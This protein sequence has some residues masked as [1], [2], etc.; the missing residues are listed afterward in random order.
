MS[1]GV[2]LSADVAPYEKMKLRLLNAGHSVLAYAA[3][4]RGHTQVHDAMQDASL[5][6]PKSGL[7]VPAGHG[8]KVCR[9]LAAPSTP[10]KPP[11]GHGS[12]VV[13]LIASLRLPAGQGMQPSAAKP[14]TSLKVPG[15]QA[16]Q[17]NS[18]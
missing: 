15:M 4:L 10:Q 2:I 12:Q 14:A 17:L 5:V 9:T 18:L 3:A 7:Y 6:A 1:P 13:A 11:L 16:L 8:L